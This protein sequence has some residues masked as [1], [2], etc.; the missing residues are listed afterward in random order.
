[1][2]GQSNDEIQ[3]TSMDTL[4]NIDELE[5]EFEDEWVSLVQVHSYM[6]QTMLI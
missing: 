1:M 5:N 4:D 3:K 6:P 2:Q